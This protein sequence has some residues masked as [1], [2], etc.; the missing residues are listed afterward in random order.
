MKCCFWFSLKAQ[1]KEL[2]YSPWKSRQTMPT[3]YTWPAGEQDTMPSE[4]DVN[5]A[6]L[7]AGESLLEIHL[8]V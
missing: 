2:A 4:E 5:V 3:Q 7:R 8:K 6:Q 1:L